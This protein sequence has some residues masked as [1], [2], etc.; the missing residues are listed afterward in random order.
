MVQ[1]ATEKDIQGILD[2]VNSEPGYLLP[3]TYEEIKESIT[4]FVVIKEG[5]EVVACASFEDYAT[6]IAEI[7]SVIVREKYRGKGYGDMMI[8]ELLKR[9]KPKQEIFVV[10]SKVEYFK[11]LGFDFCL[12]SE[13]QILFFQKK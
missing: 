2:L 6:K 12:N 9:A 8:R 13:K 4:N 5:E 10:T 3:R 1:Q 7:R 11:S